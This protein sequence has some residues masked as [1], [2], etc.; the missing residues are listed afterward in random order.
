[1]RR[2]RFVPATSPCNGSAASSRSPHCTATSSHDRDREFPALRNGYPC[3]SRFPGFGDALSRFFE[4]CNS[5]K[6]FSRSPPM[7]GTESNLCSSSYGSTPWRR[8]WNGE[9]RPSHSSSI[10]QAQ[11]ARFLPENAPGCASIQKLHP[12]TGQEIPVAW[13]T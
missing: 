9:N 4:A 13:P 11:F 2:S 12:A 10:G 8:F 3:Y 5:S 6:I 1:L 7:Q